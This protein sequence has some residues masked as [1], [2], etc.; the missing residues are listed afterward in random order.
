M[1]TVELD[2]CQIK[3][4]NLMNHSTISAGNSSHAK[5]YSYDP[6]ERKTKIMQYRQN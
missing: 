6:N 5:T 3:L 1:H 4:S 2:T